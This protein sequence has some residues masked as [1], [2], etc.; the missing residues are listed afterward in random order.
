MLAFSCR[1]LLTLLLELVGMTASEVLLGFKA[2]TKVFGRGLVFTPSK[3]VFVVASVAHP[4]GQL[5]VGVEKR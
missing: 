1:P 2:E 5:A 3:E 4:L